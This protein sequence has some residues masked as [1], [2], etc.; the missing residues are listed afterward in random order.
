MMKKI[1]C[2]NCGSE[3]Q[4]SRGAYDNILKQVR[5]QE[6]QAELDAYKVAIEQEKQTAIREAQLKAESEAQKII[7]ELNSNL[8]RIE[9]RSQRQMQEMRLQTQEQLHKMEKQAREEREALEVQYINRLHDKDAQIAQLRDF[10]AQLSTK[11]V[12]ESLERHC[13][14]AF[15]SIRTV[16]FPNAQFGKDNDAQMGSKG[17]YIYREYDES[18]VEILSIMFEMKNQSD[19]TSSKKHNEDFFKELDKD[20]KEVR[21]CRFSFNA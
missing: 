13:E 2:P 4:P 12:G 8:N 14:S 16:A 7:G 18:G 17:D 21:I 11:M 15:N 10:R 20:R 5:D 1:K 19:A 9:V 3:I 6:F